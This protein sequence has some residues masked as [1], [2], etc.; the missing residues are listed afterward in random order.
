MTTGAALPGDP[1]PAMSGN[2]KSM[3]SQHNLLANVRED[4][5][6]TQMIQTEDH[7]LV[8]LSGGGDSV[9]LLCVLMALRQELGITLEAM[10]VHH[11]IRGAEADEDAQFCQ[12]LCQR[13]QIPCHVVQVDVPAV[14]AA[15]KLSLEEAARLL[16]YRELEAY[17]RQIGAVR[18]AVAHH[19]EDQAETVL[20]NLFR[21]SGL[22]GLGGMKAVNGAVI[23]PLLYRSKEEILD[24]LREQELAWQQ[25]STND[26]QDYTRNR[27]RHHILEVAAREI[28]PQSAEH[29]SQAAA[30]A[31]QADDYLRRQ[32]RRWLETGENA[33]E[34]AGEVMEL[35][36]SRL[37]REEEILQTYILREALQHCGIPEGEDGLTDL[38]L[39]H[40]E[41]VQS[42]L[43]EMPG[44]SASRQVD[45]PKGRRARRSYGQ[46]LL[47]RKTVEG[48]AQEES[49]Q[50]KEI[51]QPVIV[52]VERGQ[53]DP[54]L[55]HYGGKAFSLRVFPYEKSQKIP[56]NQYTKWMDY[57]KI[58]GPFVFRNRQSG[59]YVGLPGGSRKTVKAYMI[60]EKIPATQRDRIPVIAQ[61]SHVLWIVGY[62]LSDRVK[63]NE[64]TRYVLE[65]QRHGG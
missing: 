57:D 5:R 64:D 51:C 38:T 18:I 52:T 42:L 8:A 53:S 40:V 47:E 46:L 15:Q 11:G 16:R 43:T 61:G 31:A 13:W 12:Q 29:I 59:D 37:Q 25:D 49:L 9:C 6:N 39:R 48:S 35:E 62:R 23:R 10:H 54:I 41:A 20:G 17:R 56:T 58:E 32:A 2:I 44:S 63:I 19:R 30:L 14:A 21:G 33:R 1:V 34:I 45:L 65:I 60:D 55:I 28:N 36:I 27:I 7:I 4:I 22:K 50:R 26:S 3:T 24:Y